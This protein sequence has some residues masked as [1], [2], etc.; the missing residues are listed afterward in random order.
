M[1]K[2]SSDEIWNY[3]QVSIGLNYRMT[4][5]AASLGLSQM[6]K[7]DAFVDKRRKIA[8]FYTTRLKNLPIRTQYE[9]ADSK[10][11]FHLYVIRLD[12]K[13]KKL[14]QKT[15][16]DK[17]TKLGVLVNIH[18]IPVYRQ[19]FYEDMGFRAGYCPEAELFQRS[20]EYT[21]LP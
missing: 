8:N 10:S 19:P 5:I 6:K 9:I 20:F 7:L 15:V 2:R 14:F 3:Q 13:N 4:D 21:N 12:L 1:R 11:T 18:Y 16:Y 17:L